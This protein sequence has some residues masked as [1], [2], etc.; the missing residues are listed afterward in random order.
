[1][2]RAARAKGRG[3]AAAGD[4]PEEA[5]GPPRLPGLC[6]LLWQAS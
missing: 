4:G 3:R 2:I 6:S 1:M 5:A